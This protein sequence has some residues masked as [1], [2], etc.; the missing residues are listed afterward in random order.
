M[1]AKR[2]GLRTGLARLPRL[3]IALAL[4]GCAS[5]PAP[6]DHYYRLDV[7]APAS[8]LE[9]PAFPGTLVVERF[10]ADAL[11][12]ERL[13]VYRRADESSEVYRHAYHYWL[14]SPTTLLPRALASYLRAAGAANRV[15]TNETRL[16]PDF[17]VE[18][19]IV[20]FERVLGGSAPAVLVEL[21]LS[22]TREADR[23]L[24]LLATYREEREADGRSIAQAVD[25]FSRALADIFARFLADAAGS[26]T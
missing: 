9:A 8:A 16:R 11:T 5:G 4:G 21:E 24:M 14:D 26:A 7:G 13:L 20:R 3:L 25:A 18:G 15:V 19:R 23:E 6:S 22:L 17:A 10:R 1:T 2:C 12:S